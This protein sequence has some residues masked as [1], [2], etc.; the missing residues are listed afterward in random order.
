MKKVVCILLAVTILLAFDVANENEN[1]IIVYSSSEQ[2]RNSKIQE[3]LNEHF[4]DK[5]IYVT[6]MSTGKA[7]SRIR[8]E[9]ENT[10]ADIIIGMETAYLQELEEDLEDVS[11]IKHQDYLDSI[12]E[13]DKYL[14]WERQ[15]GSIIVNHD[16]LDK[17]NLPVPKTYEDLLNPEYKG[18]IAMPDPKT[19]GT[20]YFFYKGLVNQWGEDKALDYFDHLSENIKQFTESGSGPVQ[21]LLQEE[22]AVG[23]GLTF[24]GVEKLNEG[25][26]FELL[27]PEFGA[28]YNLTGCGIIK[29]RKEKEGVKEVFEYIVNDVLVYDKEYFSPD[30]ILKDQKN[31]VENY[32]QNIEYAE[33]DGLENSKEKERLLD[34]WEY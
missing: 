5:E 2:F 9:G 24:Q 12:P 13:H 11:D 23:L 21:L 10:D 7:A 6:Y 15:A 31:F 16:V 8:A 33:M 26:N 30:T 17:Y 4:P 14:I 22:V 28:P 19:S 3:L 34:L 29:G 20:G 32:P 25:Y 18:L 1:A 27:Q